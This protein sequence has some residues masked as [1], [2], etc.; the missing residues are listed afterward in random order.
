MSTS[1]AAV[2]TRPFS[3]SS[4]S[5]ALTRSARSEGGS[6]WSWGWWC[7]LT[8]ASGSGTELRLAR[9]RQVIQ[10]RRGGGPGAGPHQEE[11]G[12]PRPALGRVVAHEAGPLADRQRG[13]RRLEHQR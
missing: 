2:S 10:G 8:A 3:L 9:G 1:T 13:L 4:D 5:R 12:L 6:V 7:P 11:Q